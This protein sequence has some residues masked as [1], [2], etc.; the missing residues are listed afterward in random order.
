[1]ELLSDKFVKAFK[2]AAQAPMKN[3]EERATLGSSKLNV[4][5]QALTFSPSISS[6]ADSEVQIAGCK[7]RYPQVLAL[8]R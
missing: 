4:I 7:D 2:A 5:T 6:Y 3:R 8:K 1:M